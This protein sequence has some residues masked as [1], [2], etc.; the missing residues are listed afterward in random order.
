MATLTEL[1]HFKELWES[2]KENAEN[3]VKYYEEE[4]TKK[5]KEIA[6]MVK[7]EEENK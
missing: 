6:E 2:R 1:I 3:A 5:V 4:I 7:P